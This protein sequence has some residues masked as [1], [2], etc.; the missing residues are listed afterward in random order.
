ML[1]YIALDIATSAH[2]M[3]QS[4]A[5]GKRGRIL[6]KSFCNA[7]AHTWFFHH[8]IILT[9][10]KEL[11]YEGKIFIKKHFSILKMFSNEGSH[12]IL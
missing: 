12:S 2:Q 5:L 6:M 3:I 7:E 8:P 1:R 9:L 10:K 11:H 4:L